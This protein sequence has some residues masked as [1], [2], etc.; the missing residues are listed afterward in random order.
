MH[1]ALVKYF[2]VV[3]PEAGT[4]KLRCRTCDHR[5]PHRTHYDELVQHGVACSA[6]QASRIQ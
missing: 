2:E 3:M 5:F 6:T 1:D 4:W